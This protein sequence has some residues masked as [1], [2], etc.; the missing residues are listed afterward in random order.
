MRIYNIPVLYLSYRLVHICYV[1]RAVLTH[2]T[3]LLYY[4]YLSCVYT[5]TYQAIN[6][7]IDNQNL[8]ELIRASETRQVLVQR[9]IT[10]YH[11]RQEARSSGSR[12]GSSSFG[13]GRSSGGGGGGW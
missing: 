3:A 2:C 12:G 9:I 6:S 1:L 7:A 11:T 10:D 5:G 13:G 4:P 8:T